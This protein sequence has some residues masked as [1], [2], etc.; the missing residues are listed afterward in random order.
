MNVNC[1]FCY[2][3]DMRLQWVGTRP[4]SARGGWDGVWTSWATV[5][6]AHFPSGHQHCWPI[7]SGSQWYCLTLGRTHRCFPLHYFS[8]FV[9]PSSFRCC[10]CQSLCQHQL[11]NVLMLCLRVVDILTLIVYVCRLIKQFIG[12][13]Y[14]SSPTDHCGRLKPLQILSGKWTSVRFSEQQ[15]WYIFVQDEHIWEDN[16]KCSQW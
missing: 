14:D 4:R 12:S 6:V 11:F 16:M 9:V 3:D 10:V 5:A 15:P 13:W 8:T 7:S 1:V 2:D